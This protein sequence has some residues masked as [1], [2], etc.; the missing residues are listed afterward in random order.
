M[1][2]NKGLYGGI[3]ALLVLVG[4]AVAIMLLRRR[5]MANRSRLQS[6]T[7]TAHDALNSVEQGTEELAKKSRRGYKRLRKEISKKSPF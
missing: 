2:K 3:V 7:D 5:R 1:M 6:F 4:G